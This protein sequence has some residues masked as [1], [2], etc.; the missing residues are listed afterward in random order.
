MREVR[1][2]GLV[3]KPIRTVFNPTPTEGFFD[4]LTLSA[5]SLIGPEGQGLRCILDDMSAGRILIAAQCEG[6]ER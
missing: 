4:N 6:D 1:E 2:N 5:D 3:I